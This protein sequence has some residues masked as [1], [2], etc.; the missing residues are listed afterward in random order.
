MSEENVEIV[1]EGLVA[2]AKGEI[3]GP[4]A[5]TVNFVPHLT[6]VDG[7]VYRGQKGIEAWLDEMNRAFSGIEPAISSIRNLD[8]RHVLA[9]GHTV[10]TGRESAVAIDFEWAQVVRIERGKITDVW[11]CRNEPA[12]LEAAGLTE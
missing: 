9:L 5:P 6:G 1:R 11:I 7:R 2:L 12:A 4:F 10:L 3:A 8:D